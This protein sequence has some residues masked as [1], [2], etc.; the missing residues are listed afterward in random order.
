VALTAAVVTAQDEQEESRARSQL[1]FAKS[2]M[3]SGQ[4]ESALR[5]LEAIGKNYPATKTAADALLEQARYYLEVKRDPAQARALTEQLRQKYNLSDSVPMSYVIDG[6]VALLAG[7]TP[8]DIALAIENFDRLGAMFSTSPIVPEATYRAAS[9]TRLGLNPAQAVRKYDELITRFPTSSWTPAALLESALAVIRAG[10]SPARAMERLQRVRRVFPQNPAAAT[11]LQWNTL[12][13]RLY[14]KAP[15]QPLYQSDDA[16]LAPTP[17]KL[18]DLIDLAVVDRGDLLVLTKNAVLGYPLKATPARR[19]AVSES[20]SIVPTRDGQFLIVQE[21][22]LLDA[23]GRLMPLEM[24]REGDELLKLKAND[25]VMTASGEYLVADRDRQ[26]IFRFNALRKPAGEYASRLRADRLAIDDLDQVSVLS[27]KTLVLIG[28][29]GKRILQIAERGADYRL[30][31]PVDIAVDVFG[32]IYVLDKS[33]RGTIWV[34]SP[35]SGKLI[36]S[37][38]LPD[39][40]QARALTVDQEGRLFVY[41]ERIDAIRVYR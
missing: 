26:S 23:Q 37:F 33:D 2:R 7:L 30:G 11:A 27:E 15:T 35:V 40:V 38:P 39:R 20:R 10:Q 13:Y 41:D 9:A 8:P 16:V 32:H 6:R 22:G 28:R 12:L 5:D 29:D 17:A 36:R 25:A 24:P 34:F 31:D 1:D 18:P 4:Y 14:L 3:G 21:N 19:T